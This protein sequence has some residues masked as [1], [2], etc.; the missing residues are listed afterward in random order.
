[1]GRVRG[2]DEGLLNCA[3][4]A[5]DSM[6]GRRGVDGRMGRED[7]RRELK[8]R[9]DSGFVKPQDGPTKDIDTAP[10]MT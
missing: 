4:K 10:R 9:L 2:I 7:E 6:E 3:V 1:M 8:L 5:E